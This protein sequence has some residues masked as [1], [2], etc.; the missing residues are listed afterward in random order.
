MPYF[1]IEK[2]SKGELIARIHIHTKDNITGKSK[3]VTKRIHNDQ[4]LTEARFQR[5]V[6][7]F[8]LEFENEVREAKNKYGQPQYN[9]NRILTFKEL[10]DE[11][12][13]NVKA[14]LSI[15]YY[16]KSKRTIKLFNE[17]LE[18]YNLDMLPV[19]EIQ[20]RDIQLF[21]NSF[22][23]YNINNNDK[24]T[25]RKPLPNIVS[26]RLLAKE[27]I[28]D[29]STS[30][31]LKY[32]NGKIIYDKVKK[33]CDFYNLDINEY[34]SKVDSLKGYS[35]QTIKGHR[36][37]IRA[38]FSEAVRYD[39]IA[40]NPVSQTK[41]GSAAGNAALRPV[42]EKEVYSI[43]E[44]KEFIKIL[45]GLDYDFINEKTV[46]K[47][48]LLTGVRLGEMCGIR[49]DDI[50]FEKKIVH[51]RR[52]RLYCSSIG[53]YEKVPKTKTSIR[54]IP[55][56]DILIEVLRKYFEWF[57]IADD[58]FEDNLDRYYVAANPYREPVAKASVGRWLREIQAK[59]NIKHVSCHGLRH[60][61]CSLLLSQ[62]VP[63]QTV[64]KYMGH[65]ESTITLKVYSHFMPDTQDRVINALN[66]LL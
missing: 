27:H 43:S 32:R 51:I 34:F 52:N 5:K 37:I 17:Y 57:K 58:E 46:I 25:L 41:I 3:Y 49:W 14:N 66:N 16:E 33:I 19:N 61:Y 18:K 6:E 47:F 31:N 54:D 36:Q 26:Y 40:K 45:D 65:S 35:S 1:K 2:N 9:R 42:E 48:M 62:S 30:Y 59:Y 15:N 7:L 13:A 38:V 11:F 50:D 60:T 4:N 53:V 56:P 10:S 63:I 22:N 29:R 55:L 64:S 24:Y 12:L 23:N 39:W 21:L 28:I 8:A 44:A 20:V